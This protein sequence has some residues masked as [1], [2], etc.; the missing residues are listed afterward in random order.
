MS[1][2]DEKHADTKQGPPADPPTVPNTTSSAELAPLLIPPTSA[3][4]NITRVLRRGYDLSIEPS[5]DSDPRTAVTPTAEG[6]TILRAFMRG[7]L[8][9]IL[10]PVILAA[11]VLAATAAMIYGTGK[12][13]EGIGRAIVWGPEMLYKIHLKNRVEKMWTR[14][15]GGKCAQSP[16]NL[17]VEAGPIAL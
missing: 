1:G 5:T 9:I 15:A 3:G 17:D 4:E 8:A 13:I 14:V 10:P 16:L 12:T 6:R 7:L 2:P 11:L